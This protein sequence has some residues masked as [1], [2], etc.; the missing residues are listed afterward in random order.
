M[1]PDWAFQ[2]YFDGKIVNN[3]NKMI[4]GNIWYITTTTIFLPYQKTPKYAAMF[5]PH[6]WQ[7]MV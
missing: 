6:S 5:S 2:S 1:N 3:G 4:D 7:Y